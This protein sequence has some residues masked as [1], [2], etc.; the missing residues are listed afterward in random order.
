MDCL[1]FHASNTESLGGLLH[2]HTQTDRQTDR[3]TDGQTDRQTETE[4]HTHTHTHTCTQHGWFRAHGPGASHRGPAPRHRIDTSRAYFPKKLWHRG[5]ML[6]GVGRGGG[7]GGGGACYHPGD[8]RIGLQAHEQLKQ[9]AQNKACLSSKILDESCFDMNSGCE[10]HSV[11]F[12][13]ERY[14]VTTQKGS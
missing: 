6:G 14:Q 1:A 10:A 11:A 7:G 9:N 5:C 13:K 2:T 3:R 8:A 12:K 4:T